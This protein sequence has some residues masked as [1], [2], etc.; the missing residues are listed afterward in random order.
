MTF[1][2]NF[3]GQVMVQGGAGFKGITAAASYGNFTVFW[4]DA[5]FHIKLSL[6]YS[7]EGAILTILCLLSK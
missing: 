6:R 7:L 5:F 2:T 4:V 1:G 3:Q